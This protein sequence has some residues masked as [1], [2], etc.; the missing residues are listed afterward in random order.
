VRLAQ[1]AQHIGAR[2]S[3]ANSSLAQWKIGA[4]P[5]NWLQVELESALFLIT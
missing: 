3:C 4:S 1:V 5:K 2:I